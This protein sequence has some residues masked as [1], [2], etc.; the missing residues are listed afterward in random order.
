MSDKLDE[1]KEEA[2]QLGI[3][4]NVNIKEEKLQEKIDAFYEAEAKD[5]LVEVKKEA[6]KAE[7]K[8]EGNKNPM[9]DL[10]KATLKELKKYF[11]SD[12]NGY[13]QAVTKKIEMEAKKTSVV[14]I[15][16]VDKDEA[17]TA[18]SAYFNN[19][20][21]AMRVPLDVYVEMPKA[22]IDMAESARTT[23]HQKTKDG[24]TTKD[25]KRYV[26]ERK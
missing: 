20:N 23:I 2:T 12:T 8:I 5:S 10:T 25:S 6:P 7:T 22:L 18:T 11:G 4:F 16:M 3:K 9:Q 19:G 14:K 24:T 21:M 17:S 1:L 15:T 26:V 13:M